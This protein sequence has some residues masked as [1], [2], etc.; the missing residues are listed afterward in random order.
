[1]PN[2]ASMSYWRYKRR[3]ADRSRRPCSRQRKWRV[4]DWTRAIPRHLGKI[5]YFTTRPWLG[6]NADQRAQRVGNALAL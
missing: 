6:L 3:G 4:P 2:D 5:F 1:M